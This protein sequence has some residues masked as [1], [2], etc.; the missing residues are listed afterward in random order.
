M[1]VTSVSVEPEALALTV[2]DGEGSW[3]SARPAA[4]G[5]SGVRNSRWSSGAAAAFPS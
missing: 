2:S 4:G 3:V 5:A 1:G